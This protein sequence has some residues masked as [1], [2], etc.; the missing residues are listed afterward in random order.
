M[1][2]KILILIFLGSV[3]IFSARAQSYRKDSASIAKISDS[4][5]KILNQTI[6]SLTSLKESF[7]K[8][9][10]IPEKGDITMV[11]NLSLILVK[12]Q[13]KTVEENKELRLTLNK[14]GNEVLEL[15]QTIKRCLKEGSKQ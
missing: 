15:K 6:V 10:K 2:T 9:G 1:K 5:I 13:I 14:L 11:I 4:T 12:K 3:F 8:T 7:E